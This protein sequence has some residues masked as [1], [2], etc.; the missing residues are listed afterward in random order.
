MYSNSLFII[1]LSKL[2]S[3]LVQLKQTKGKRGESHWEIHSRQVGASLRNKRSSVLFTFH[4]KLCFGKIVI[5]VIKWEGIIYTLNK[6]DFF[7]FLFPIIHKYNQAFQWKFIFIDTLHELSMTETWQKNIDIKPPLLMKCYKSQL[8]VHCHFS[9]LHTLIFPKLF[10]LI[11]QR[12]LISWPRIRF[13]VR[14][15]NCYATKLD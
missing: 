4:V 11:K 12:V 8:R 3:T 15:L 9:V 1:S 5:P 6:P 2:V 7:V 10:Q 13:C 14:L